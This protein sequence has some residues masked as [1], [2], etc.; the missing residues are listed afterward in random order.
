MKT[1]ITIMSNSSTDKHYFNTEQIK[2]P[3]IL[4]NVRIT[5][6]FFFFLSNHKSL[7][8]SEEGENKAKLY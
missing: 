4:F 3:D 2:A 6:G 8:Q 5:E 1:E 7:N